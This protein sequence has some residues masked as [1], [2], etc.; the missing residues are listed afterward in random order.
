M[1]HVVVTVEL[2]P[3]EKVDLAK[4]FTE[5]NQQER[6]SQMASLLDI[7]LEGKV[8]YYKRV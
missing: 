2:S 1:S 8:E 7:A 5:T 4:K 6:E 3:K